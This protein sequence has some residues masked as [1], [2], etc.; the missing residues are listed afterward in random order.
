MS[1]YNI[2]DYIAICIN[3]LNVFFL[4]IIV[5]SILYLLSVQRFV[6]ITILSYD[7]YG[8]NNII[9]RNFVRIV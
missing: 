5:I 4:I 6:T 9:T 7:Q 8:L 2:Y 3:F 1:N